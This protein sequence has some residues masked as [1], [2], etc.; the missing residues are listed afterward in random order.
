MAEK[1]FFAKSVS[2]LLECPK[3]GIASR[4]LEKGRGMDVSVFAFDA[5][6]SLSEHSSA[7]PAVIQI[8]SGTAELVLGG[9]KVLA[10]S[11]DLIFMPKGLRHSVL[12]KTK[13]KMLLIL[14][15]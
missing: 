3:G 11:G 7:F 5:G 13:M 1:F 4:Q 10:R 14:S 12:A 15:K 6:Q 9:K 2:K 8:L